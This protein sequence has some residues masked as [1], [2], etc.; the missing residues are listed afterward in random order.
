MKYKQEMMVIANTIGNQAK[1]EL[2][3]YNKPG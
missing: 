3:A 1:F 2:R